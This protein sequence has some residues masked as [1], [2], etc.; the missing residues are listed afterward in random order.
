MSS[1][2]GADWAGKPVLRIAGDMGILVEFGDAYAPAV[3]NAV[4]AFD[5]AIRQ[6]TLAG[7]IETVPT[8]RSVLVRFDPLELPFDRL[9]ARLGAMLAERD[10]YLAPPPQGRREWVLPAVYGGAS[11]PDLAEVGQKL[12]VRMLLGEWDAVVAEDSPHDPT[13][14]RIRQDG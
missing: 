5:A 2:E 14:L 9:E 4:L 8:F 13:N 1:A 11:G 12:K 6:M 7:V 10:W 3:S